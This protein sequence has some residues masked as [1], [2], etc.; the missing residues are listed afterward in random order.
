MSGRS[1]AAGRAMAKAVGVAPTAPTGLSG[2]GQGALG[3]HPIDLNSCI[4][5]YSAESFLTTN[6]DG[7]LVTVVPS[8]TGNRHPMV[9]GTGCIV[10]VSQK[11]GL[12]ALSFNGTTHWHR[13]AD[14]GYRGDPSTHIVV[15]Q[16]TIADDNAEHWIAG[17]QN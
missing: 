5:A 4:H 16:N 2:F 8:I 6:V 3:F 14:S 12:P 11:S 15:F 7:D 17:F 10:K 13:V 9:T 1:R